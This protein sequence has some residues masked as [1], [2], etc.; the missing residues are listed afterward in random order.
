[1]R[2]QDNLK[3]EQFQLPLFFYMHR[4]VVEETIGCECQAEVHDEVVC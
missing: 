1:M 3:H 2:V 4:L